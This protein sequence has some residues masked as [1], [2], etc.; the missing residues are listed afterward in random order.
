LILLAFVSSLSFIANPATP[1]IPS[2]LAVFPGT[3]VGAAEY[4][5]GVASLY[6]Q[7]LRLTIVLSPV[8]SARDEIAFWPMASQVN[9]SF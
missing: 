5:I 3:C 1:E 4:L 6:R 9:F 2:M 7:G 8:P